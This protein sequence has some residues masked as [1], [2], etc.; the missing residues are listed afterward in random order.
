[1]PEAGFYLT[2][3]IYYATGEPHLGHAYTTILGD[4]IARYHRQA[5]RSVMFLTG[6][7]EHGQ[8]IQEE[9]NRRELSPQALA[10]QM[11]QVFQAAW[12]DLGI[13]HDRFMRTTDPDHVSIVRLVYERLWASDDIYAGKYEGWYCVHEERYWTEKDLGPDRTCP[14][15]GRP[16][17]LIDEKNYF[18]RMSNYQDALIRHIE[19]NPDWITPESRRNEVLGFLAGPLSDLSVSRPKSRVAWGIELPFDSD[20]V[21][22][23]W[24][25]AL[26]NYVTASGVLDPEAG[27]DQPGF[28]AG[29]GGR[30]PAD[31]HLIGKDIL[32]TH[33]V[34]WPTLLMACGLD[35]PKRVLAHGWWVVS[36]TKMSKSLGNVV[37]PLTLKG[38]VGTDAVRWYLLREMPT[39]SDASYTPDRF[40]TRY[41]ELSNVLGNLVHRVTSMILKYRDGVVPSVGSESAA[42]PESSVGA[43][44][45]GLN[46]L[47]GPVDEALALYR[48]NM[49]SLRLHDALA[50]AMELART[51]NSFI[52]EQEPW[53]LARD[54]DRSAELDQTLHALTRC[55]TAVSAMLFPVM[56]ERMSRL[57]ERL[58]LQDVP[59]LDDAMD[60]PVGGRRVEK[61][62]ALF[63]RVEISDFRT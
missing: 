12:A 33:C 14:D 57:V 55:L 15:C 63:P 31:L 21:A 62:E 28:E 24:L 16:V 3:P 47:R 22:Y 17:Q 52:E 37:D 23:V 51:A 46:R 59:T 7:D 35:L 43:A 20:H 44:P 18:F 32:T 58:G 42:G 4:A 8:K 10:D 60:I 36:D 30:W 9:A 45:S 6:T 56:P 2:T 50:A 53:V 5:G 48:S 25:D 1:M 13:S 61:G 38:Q 34:Y 39:G 49:E 26:F 27:P 11:A 54:P 29:R 19:E 40:L 41:G